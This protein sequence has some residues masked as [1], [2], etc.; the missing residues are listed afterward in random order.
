MLKSPYPATRRRLLIDMHVPDWD[1]GMLRE[2][3]PA[4]LIGA[5]RAANAS[6]VMVYFNSHTG[7]CNWP[8]R[9][10]RRHRAFAGRDVMAETLRAARRH[11]LPLCAYYSVNFNN[12]AWEE[13]PDWRLVPAAPAMIGGGLLQRERYGV[14]CFNHA[15]YREFV[16]L[17]VQEILESYA[18]DA[19]FFDMMWWMSVC[20]C[21]SCRRR[22]RAEQGME[23]PGIIDWLDPAWCRYQRA[24][25]QWLTGFACELRD[26]VRAARPG[27]AV[28]HNFAVGLT[29]WT[30]GVA[31][32]SARAHD[33]LGG[34]FYGDRDEQL[35]V[36][37]LMLNLS[38]GSP[39]EFMTTVTGNLAEHERL[40]PAELLRSQSSAAT[41]CG[42]AFLAILAIDPDGHCHPGAIDRVRDVFARRIPHETE[43]GGTAIE[44]IAV[45]FSDSSKMS[46]LD[47]GLPLAQAPVSQAADYPHLHA[48]QG[49]CRIL[50]QAQLP[51]GIITRRQLG[52]LAR[53]AVIILPNVLRM[54]DEEIAALRAYVHAGGRLYASRFTSLT[55]TTGERRGDLMLADVFGCHFE[56][57]ETGRNLHLE[58]AVGRYA[59]A[60][61]PERMVSHWIDSR[62]RT[63]A[64]RLAMQV[65]G[66][67]LMTLTLPYG[68]PSRGSVEGRDWASIH[69]FPPW[70][71]TRIP[72]VVANDYGGGRA[73]YSAAD[74]ES[75]GSRAHDV[76]FLALVRSLLDRR[77]AFSADAHPCVWM[78]AYAQPERSRWLLCFLNNTRE[79]PA[80]PLPA[81]RFRLVAPAG[82]AFTRLQILANGADIPFSI[83]ESG[84]LAAELSGLEELIMVG[85]TYA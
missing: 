59:D 21:A 28:Y 47:N 4:A 73:I 65:E 20:L 69:S 14:C 13:H 84:T 38:G 32:E 43:L 37:K 36:S 17:Q 51:F 74:L 10:G 64:V 18:V 77:P 83:D 27:I 50:Q 33:F 53:Y 46:F 25:E 63:G 75:G 42:A 55:S 40:K 85:A 71:R 9:S 62:E 15:G 30:R 57:F 29:N 52:E 8:T 56:A 66:S 67:V 2:F 60:I 49:A 31:F 58:P 39:V 44:E 48:V 54:D 19:F 5:A 78:A 22:L 81:F 76:S 35:V 45:Y 41:A 11:E 72:V 26:V 68:Y 1:P 7:L 70:E 12:C 3:D 34:D 24:R 82:T 16:K 61:A 79:L 6:A 23:I 80:V